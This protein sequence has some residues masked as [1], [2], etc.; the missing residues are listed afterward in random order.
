DVGNLWFINLLAARDDLRQLAR[1][2]QVSLLKI[3]AI[4]RKYA[5]DV[6]AWQAGASF[7]TEV[8]LVGPMIVA[9]ARRILALGVE[10][11]ALETRLEA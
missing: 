5:A 11:K 8:E 10:I 6:L 2:R 7:S 4:G 3:P 9:D 1:M